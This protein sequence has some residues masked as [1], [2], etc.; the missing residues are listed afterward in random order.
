MEINHEYY[1]M[2]FCT[3]TVIECSV[4]V[5]VC[6]AFLWF[7]FNFNGSVLLLFLRTLH[8]KNVGLLCY[9]LC[10]KQIHANIRVNIVLN[11]TAA[12]IKPQLKLFVN[13][14]IFSVN[15][16]HRYS[17]L[18]AGFVSHTHTH[19]ERESDR[20]QAV[21]LAYVFPWMCWW[22]LMQYMPLSKNSSHSGFAQTLT[23]PVYPY[24][25]I[26]CF[27]FAKLNSLFAPK[28]LSFVEHCFFVW[29]KKE[30]K[31]KITTVSFVA[32]IASVSTI[33]CFPFVYR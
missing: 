17:F 3:R 12:V 7:V 14:D 13:V 11:N 21:R 31:K 24:M 6:Y 16:M 22:R 5:C 28:L 2:T 33:F 26:I 29:K 25:K 19:T 18:F 30:R 15:C 20:R 9:V 10:A 23:F 4:C 27:I 8:S 1:S 32:K